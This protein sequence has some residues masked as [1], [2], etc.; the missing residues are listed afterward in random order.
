M[1]VRRTRRSSTQRCRRSRPRLGE[2][3][4]HPGTALR[5]VEMV[6]RVP[7]PYELPAGRDLLHLC[8]DD[9]RVLR[10]AIRAQVH[11]V[12]RH[13]ALEQVVAIRE[14]LELVT[15]GLDVADGRDAP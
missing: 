10:T 5:Q 9:R 11:V 1:A 3:L 13:V 14:H 2:D 8:V 6:L 7:A 4:T 12:T 15:V